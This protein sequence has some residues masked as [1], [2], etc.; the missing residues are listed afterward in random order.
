MDPKHGQGIMLKNIRSYFYGFK[1]Y[2]EPL[3][4]YFFPLVL[5]LYPLIGV[6]NGIDI[7]DTTYNLANYEY[8]GSLDP[9]WLLSTFLG[10]LTGRI[11][12]LL[13]GASSMMGFG[14]Y[15]SFIIS[16]VA[17]ISYYNII[18]FMPGWMIFIGMFIAESLCWCPRVIL[19]N[20]LT[21]LLMT[22]GI[23][24]LIKGTFAW[25]K[26][27]L[28]LILAGVCLGL[29]VL[30]RFPNIVE[31]AFILILWFY[32]F[33]TRQDIKSLLQKTGLCILG[34][35]VGFVV[36]FIGI[37]IRYGWNSYFDMLG[38]LFGMTEGAKDYSTGGMLS[39]IIEAYAGTLKNMLY[40]FPCIAVGAVLFLAYKD[41]FVWVKKL[42]YFIGLL[43]VVRY[44][45]AAGVFTRNY[46]YY[47]SIFKAAMMFIIFDIIIAFIGSLG[48]LNGSRQEQTIAFAV[49]MVIFIT[50]IGSNNYT[51]PVLNNLFLVAPV[52]LWLFRRLMQRLGEEEYNFAWQAVYTVIVIVLLIQGTLFHINFSFE[53]GSNGVKRDALTMQIPKTRAMVT[54]GENAESLKELNEGLAANDLG[55]KKTIFFGG[56]PGISYIFDLEPAIDTVWPDLD[57]YSVEKFDN[58]LMELSAS[59]D[60]LP[61]VII[62]KNMREYANSATKYDILM[63]YIANH[64][65]NKVFESE[66]F[67]IYISDHE[68]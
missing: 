26:Q 18:K 12:M 8:M 47:D 66:K 7:T 59:G 39:S 13:P 44:Y 23:I 21:Y 34:Y 33:I 45:F 49:L 50:P 55:D 6:T 22:V 19:Y 17:L 28:Y 36:P 52:S 1:K 15:C 56:I 38:S 2:Q 10:N 51:Y 37:S 27:E 5:L 41:R 20:Y 57:S 25:R 29:N 48:L 43:V 68:G 42:L 3:E 60:L 14:I 54:T 24:F 62:G 64:D 67:I 63:D 11:I 16:A 30:V 4:K 58:S 46:F 65:Y 53:D 40:L 32:C 9:M 31:A 35:L 61:T